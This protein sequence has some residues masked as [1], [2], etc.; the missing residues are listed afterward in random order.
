MSTLDKNYK[1]ELKWLFWSNICL[2][3]A[4]AAIILSLV[5]F[6]IECNNGKLTQEVAS[7]SIPAKN[8][9][10]IVLNHTNTSDII[11][12]TALVN[13]VSAFH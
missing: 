6:A 11:N 7:G 1:D 2:G 13:N 8:I 3:I 12:V 10:L 4:I 5:I 9:Y